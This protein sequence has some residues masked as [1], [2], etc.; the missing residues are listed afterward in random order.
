MNASCFS[1]IAA[2]VLVGGI[3]VNSLVDVAE[4]AAFGLGTI[5]A[6]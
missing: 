6:R 5:V 1:R 4:E 3:Q 2:K